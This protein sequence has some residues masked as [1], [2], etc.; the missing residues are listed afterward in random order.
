MDS[1]KFRQNFSIV[2]LAQQDVPF[3]N[4][5]VK[6][7]TQWVQVGV[8]FPDDYFFKLTE[9]YNTSVTNAACIEGIA[10]LIFGKGMYSKN[11]QFAEVLKQLLPSEELKNTIFDLKLFGNAALQVVWN[12]E[13]T[14]IIKFYHSPVQ[15]FRAEKLRGIPKI[16][17]YY[18]CVDWFDQKAVRN[19]IKIPAFGT[20][21]EQ[22]ELL[23]LK[24]YCPG[25]FYYSLPDWFP[26]LQYSE[27]EAELSN[28]HINNIQ[29]GFLPM[30]MVNFNNGVPAPEE[31][32][33]IEGLIGA[34]FTGTRNAGRFM[35]SFN[36]DPTTKPTIDV[37]QIDN[38]HEK[39]QY[40]ASYAQEQILVAH[41]VTS[42]LLFGVRTE[43][44]TGFSSQS[45]EMQTAFSILQTM[46]IS[47]YQN[48]ILNKLEEVLSIGGW[49]N[50]DL[51]F[52]QLTPLALLSQQAEDTGKS[53]SDIA[54][55]TNREMENPAT[56]EDAADKA[57]ETAENQPIAKG[58]AKMDN[59]NINTQP[60]ISMSSPNFKKEYEIFKQK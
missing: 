18:Y 51:Y 60:N 35:T 38:L 29:N 28:L 58:T 59:Q 49:D 50:T 42:P 33:T 15:H 32:E 30:V 4:E 46:T 1:K 47:P 13:H 21:K 16:E 54:D 45:E 31:R 12:D 3:V 57:A 2:N 17:N 53:I 39:F 40:V 34:K 41:R 36:D 8:H 19:K 52:D 6:S 7:R 5:D 37:I 24:N 22:T 43:K 48:L 10:D 55:E 23:Y 44:G 20:S 56:A 9:A 27:V 14:K 26:A 11:E 25:H